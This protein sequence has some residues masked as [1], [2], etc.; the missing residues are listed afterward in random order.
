MRHIRNHGEN[1]EMQQAIDRLANALRRCHACTDLDSL[2]GMEG[3][4]AAIYFSVFQHLLR[5][6]AFIFVRREKRP[7]RDPVNALLSWVYTLLTHDCASALQGVG[8]DPY[9]GFMHRD[10]P[11]RVSLALDMVEEFRASFA[12]RFVLTLFNRGEIKMSDFVTEGSGAVRLKDESRK[13]LL[14]AFQTKKQEEIVHPYFQE[15]IS[16]GL[17]PHCQAML[18]ARHLRGDTEFYPPFVMK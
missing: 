15:K 11:G 12:D 2:R 5:N 17:L 4:A 6:G 3:E 10:R 14:A 16:L 8:L 1:S 13:N 7:V 9:V 18:L